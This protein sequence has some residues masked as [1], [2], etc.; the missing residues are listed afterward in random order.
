MRS[1]AEVF[2]LPT[3]PLRPGLCAPYIGSV[4]NPK[5]EAERCRV[6]RGKSVGDLQHLAAP[7]V[8]S[9]QICA[10]PCQATPA[11][12]HAHGRRSDAP[13]HTA[14]ACRQG[15]YTFPRKTFERRIN[16][17]RRPGLNH[18]CCDWRR[19]HLP[20]APT[21]MHPVVAIIAATPCPVITVSSTSAPQTTEHDACGTLCG[22]LRVRGLCLTSPVGHPPFG[23]QCD[24]RD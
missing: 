18:G 19:S 12:W 8:Q 13:A 5:T 4:F 6:D 16:V 23:T 10:A 2:Q 20:G 9:Q 11:V 21:A 24:V 15:S 7:Q 17:H 3:I 14:S 22:T 1:S